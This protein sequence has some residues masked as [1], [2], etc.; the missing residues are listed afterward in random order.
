MSDLTGLR[1]AIQIIHFGPVDPV[2]DNFDVFVHFE[3]GSRFVATFFTLANIRRLFEKNRMTGELADGTYFCATDL[4]LVREYSVA[5][6][7]ATV[8]DLLADG[9]FARAFSSCPPPDP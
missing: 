4:I 8:R 7:E 6:F 2:H 5:V 1:F 9:S 3:D